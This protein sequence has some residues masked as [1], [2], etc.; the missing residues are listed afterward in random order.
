MDQKHTEFS[1]RFAIDPIAAAAMGTDELRHNFHIEGLFQPGLV[2][3][4]YTHYDRMIVGGAMPV[5]K[6]LPLEAIKP[7]GTK[8]F[9]DRRELIAVNIGGAGTVTADGPPY[10]MA[11]RDMVYLGMG[12][13]QVSFA[14]A[15]PEKPAKFYL[16][17]A[18]AHQVY[19][20]Q[21]IRIGDARRLD[22]GSQATSNERSIFQFIHADGV[23]TCQLVVGMTQLAPGSVWNTMPCHVHDRRMEAYLYFDLAEDA[24]VFHFMGEP[25]ETRHIVMRNEEAVLSPGWSIHSGAGTSNYAFIWAMAGDNVDYTD[26]DPVTLDQ[27]R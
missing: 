8:A 24:R 2:S 7:T 13:E 26:V 11:A 5:D 20:S 6:V 12:T 9:L 3:L 22:L 16:L 10:E 4:T 1:A 18:P 23:K 25:D 17:S 19:P 15:D 27:L 21:L 14:S